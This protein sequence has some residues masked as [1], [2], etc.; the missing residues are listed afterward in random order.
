[1]LENIEHKRLNSNFKN[2][3]SKCKFL[4]T[5]N[6]TTASQ[7][8]ERRQKSSI[9]VYPSLDVGHGISRGLVFSHARTLTNQKTAYAS[10]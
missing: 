8:A 1:M 5:V 6:K 10:A 4:Q 3:F 2:Y 9:I 7:N